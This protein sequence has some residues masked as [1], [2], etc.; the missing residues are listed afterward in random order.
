VAISFIQRRDNIWVQVRILHEIDKAVLVDNGMKTWIPK[1]HIHKIR[2]RDN[3][4]EV[5]VK[6]STVG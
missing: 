6:E 1:S 2:L 5:H 4:F 3:I